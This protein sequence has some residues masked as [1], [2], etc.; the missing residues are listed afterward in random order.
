MSNDQHRLLA[1]FNLKDE[2]LKAM[3]EVLVALATRVAI[4]ERV[5]L[6]RT[7]LLRETLSDFCRRGLAKWGNIWQV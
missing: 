4:V 5:R 1:S 6:Q 7:K 3:N 2:R